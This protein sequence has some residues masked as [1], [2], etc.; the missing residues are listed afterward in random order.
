MQRPRVG[1]GVTEPRAGSGVPASKDGSHT[2]AVPGVCLRAAPH[3]QPQ[4]CRGGFSSDPAINPPEPL[5]IPRPTEASEGTLGWE[6]DPG[7]IRAAA[8]SCT[9]QVPP[10]RPQF[11]LCRLR[12]P[13]LAQLP[14]IVSRGI[15]RL[16]CLA[17]PCCGRWEKQVKKAWRGSRR[18]RVQWEPQRPGTFSSQSSL[19]PAPLPRG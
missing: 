19:A 13:L 5:P 2:R 18:G 12:R 15:V 6:Q 14:A 3:C 8:G 1:A 7:W 4:Q 11:L 10:S 9:G 17:P 16:G